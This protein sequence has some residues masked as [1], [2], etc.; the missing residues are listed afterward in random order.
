MIWKIIAFIIASGAMIS[1]AK[2]ACDI[3][4][5]KSD[6]FVAGPLILVVALFAYMKLLIFLIAKKQ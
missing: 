1:I 2:I 3:T 6:L 5:L 4:S